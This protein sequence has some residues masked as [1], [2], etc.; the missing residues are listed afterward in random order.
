MKKIFIALS[1]LAMVGFVA[2]PAQALVGMPDAVPGTHLIQPFFLVPIPGTTGTD[3]TLMA[4]TEVGGYAGNFHWFIMN[5]YS[6]EMAN[7]HVDYT[8]FDVV[9]L[10]AETLV[11][12]NVSVDNL[13][14]LEVDLDEDPTTGNSRGNE[15]YMGYIIYENSNTVKEE[16]DYELP[17][18]DDDDVWEH[19]DWSWSECGVDNF[20]GHM[21]VVDMPTG[22]AS[23]AI[24]P[25]REWSGRHPEHDP[26]FIGAYWPMQNSYLRTRYNPGSGLVEPYPMFTDYEVFTPT[27]LAYSADREHSGF[28]PDLRMPDTFRLLPRFFLKDGTGETFFFIWS[29]GNWGSY[30]GTTDPD[31]DGY[32][33]KYEVVINMYDEDETVFSG[34][35]NIPYELNYINVRNKIPS[36]WLGVALGG[37]FDIRWDF[38]CEPTW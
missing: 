34:S 33:D 10:N 9:V 15:Y 4:L 24:I 23:G 29:S 13:L 20:I 16:C 3:N 18:D 11:I 27:A 38:E 19:P 21:Y 7:G 6:E 2:V 5:R 25:A 12:N 35:I 22:R 31:G 30:F 28:E 36:H 1:V 14:R 17:G 26:L 37:W 8:P 32:G